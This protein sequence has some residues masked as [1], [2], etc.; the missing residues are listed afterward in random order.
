MNVKVSIYLYMHMS[1]IRQSVLESEIFGP[2]NC[3]MWGY[4]PKH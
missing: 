3:V 2:A 1:Y 4:L